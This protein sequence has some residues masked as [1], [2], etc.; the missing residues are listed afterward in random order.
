MRTLLAAVLFA[1]TLLVPAQA[2]E[3]K[4]T[5]TALNDFVGQYELAD[6]RVLTVT[7]RAR[8][9]VAQVEGQAAVPLRPAGPGR[10]STPDGQLRVA[11][12]QHANGNVTGVVVDVPAPPGSANQ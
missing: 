12:D 9:L 8:Q 1:T 2:R 11:F 4:L 10:F 7:Q 3:S 5:S 6:G